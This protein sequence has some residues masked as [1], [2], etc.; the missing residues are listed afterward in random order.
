MIRTYP[1]TS[2]IVP[3]KLLPRSTRYLFLGYSCDHKGYG[4]PTF[5]L[6]APSSLDMFSM[7]MVSP[8]WLLPTSR[9]QLSSRCRSRLSTSPSPTTGPSDLFCAMHGSFAFDRATCGLV[10]STHTTRRHVASNHA[11]RRPTSPTPLHSLRR[12]RPHL[13]ATC[14]AWSTG[15]LLR[16]A[17]PC[18]ARSRD[19]S[20]VHYS[21]TIHHDPR[22][23]HPMVTCHSVGVLRPADRLVLTAATA[24]A[25]QPCSAMMTHGS[26]YYVM[27]RGLTFRCPM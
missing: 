5:S 21:I 27:S 14:V 12:S 11:T 15:P 1:N 17:I 6:V 3:H 2:A 4:A 18:S 19:K 23:V 9:P 13:P 16:R 26:L 22:H 24:Q 20:S 8:C 25:L 7:R 10:A